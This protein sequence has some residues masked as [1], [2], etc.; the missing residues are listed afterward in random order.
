ML[1][2]PSQLRQSSLPNQHYHREQG[3]PRRAGNVGR[4]TGVVEPR[5]Q[6][7]RN[8]HFNPHARRSVSQTFQQEPGIDEL[9]DPHPV[10][11]TK[12]V[13]YDR[14]RNAQCK[15]RRFRWRGIS[16]TTADS[17]RQGVRERSKRHAT[18]HD[19]RADGFIP[20]LVMDF[21]AA[22]DDLASSEEAREHVP[23]VCTPSTVRHE[24]YSCAISA[25]K[26][27]GSGRKSKGTGGMDAS[28]PDD[29]EDNRVTL[30]AVTEEGKLTRPGKH[31]KRTLVPLHL[32]TVL[33]TMSQ[34]IFQASSKRFDPAGKITV[35]ARHISS[36][37]IGL[38][39]MTSVRVCT[40]ART[41][42]VVVALTVAT[43]VCRRNVSA[44]RHYSE[45]WR[46]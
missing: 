44:M 42:A 7:A 43:A 19:T 1:P 22:H 38:T 16:A 25:P 29:D 6:Y 13:E 18:S 35:S 14:T 46:A 11:V 10:I 31:P 27:P 15:R 24:C 12:A 9:L 32:R 36:A 41:R 30:G 45:P 2:V 17:R 3:G 40:C 5:K 39:P 26:A 8:V 37:G 23:L 21:L 28:I 33:C 4:R 34:I 20:T